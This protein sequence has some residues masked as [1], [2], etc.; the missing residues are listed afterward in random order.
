VV[1]KV[2]ILEREEVNGDKYDIT[3]AMRKVHCISRTGKRRSLELST[4]SAT[5]HVIQMKHK[6]CG[7]APKG[8]LLTNGYASSSGFI[9]ND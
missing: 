8:P 7:V 4:L 9:G 6:Y 1:V 5:V 3:H 2:K